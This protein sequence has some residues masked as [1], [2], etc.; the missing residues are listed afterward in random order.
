MLTRE[1]GGGVEQLRE[2]KLNYRAIVEV[3]NCLLAIYIAI[4]VGKK[5]IFRQ[6]FIHSG[7]IKDSFTP[8]VFSLLNL[9]FLQ[10]NSLLRWFYLK[11]I[12][13]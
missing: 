7:S 5:I 9:L 12:G 3:H 2:L 1:Y 4:I 11:S 8:N 13:R 6:N 10:L